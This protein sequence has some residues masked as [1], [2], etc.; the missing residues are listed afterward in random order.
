MLWFYENNSFLDVNEMKPTVS[1][2][3]VENILEEN[4][5]REISQSDVNDVNTCVFEN[6]I[7]SGLDE[8]SHDT[9]SADDVD[10]TPPECVLPG[11]ISIN[12]SPKKRKSFDDFHTF[13]KNDMDGKMKRLV[14]YS[15]R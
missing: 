10:T 13:I 1:T 3:N 14:N 9:C 5:Q 8:T 7:P 11:L 2:L 15:E 6:Q 12:I 4:V